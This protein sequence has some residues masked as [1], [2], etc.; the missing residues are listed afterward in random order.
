MSIIIIAYTCISIYKENHL[1]EIAHIHWMIT[2]D[3]SLFVHL[4]YIVVN[5]ELLTFSEMCHLI[6]RMYKGEWKHTQK[7][8]HLHNWLHFWLEISFDWVYLNHF[9]ICGIYISYRKLSCAHYLLSCN[10]W[11][12]WNGNK[13]Q[14]K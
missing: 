7:H 10:K 5:F 8:H 1:K 11:N 3:N 9:H 14:I 12:D 4:E 13:F 2:M 6:I